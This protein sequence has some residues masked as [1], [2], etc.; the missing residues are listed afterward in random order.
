MIALLHVFRRRADLCLEECQGYWREIHGPLVLQHAAALRAVR[1][2]QAHTIDHPLA[3]AVRASRAEIEPYDGV[4]E[5]C[6]KDRQD[7]AAALV[8]PEGKTAT[9]ELLED[10]R[11]FIDHSRSSL[12]LA[13]KHVFI[14]RE[15]EGKAAEQSSITKLF[16]A[17]RR[18]PSLSLDECLSYWREVH[19]PLA[20]Q[21]GA[22]FPMH[23]YVQAHTMVDPL[24]DV[25]RSSRGAMAPYDGVAQMEAD[26]AELVMAAATPQGQRA[27]EEFLADERRFIDPAR[28]SLWLAK[29]EVIFESGRGDEDR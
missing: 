13:K 14:D 21:P 26:L 12:W 11:H 9:A 8:S 27:A 10:E 28:S 2:V 15:R 29:E 5:F 1:Y 4:A 25:L 23:R 22:A 3:D 17:F 18:L 24:N 6:W 19:G 7:L 20:L 16:F